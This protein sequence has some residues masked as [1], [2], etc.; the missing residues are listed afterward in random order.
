M[1]RLN[2]R[3]PY[4]QKKVDGKRCFAT[5]NDID[6]FASNPDDNGGYNHTDEILCYVPCKLMTVRT[7]SAEALS[8]GIQ[9]A[10]HTRITMFNVQ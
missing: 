10:C 9:M 5:S 3:C 8:Y 4:V 1:T 2:A 7:D 6:D